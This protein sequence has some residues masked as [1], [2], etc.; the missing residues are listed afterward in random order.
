MEVTPEPLL[1]TIDEAARCLGISRSLFYGL[2]R[3][4]EIHTV[5]I[6]SNRRVA[7]ADLQD[8]VNRLRRQDRVVA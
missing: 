8:Y 2:M 4:G 5:T 7:F 1:L 6:R 3:N